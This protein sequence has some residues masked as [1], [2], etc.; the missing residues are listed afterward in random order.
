MP[1]IASVYSVR[2]GRTT[3]K[4]AGRSPLFLDRNYRLTGN[5]GR[6]LH[7]HTAHSTHAAT[8]RAM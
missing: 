1:R 5:Y 3:K 2:A 8:R 4:R 6:Q 7:I